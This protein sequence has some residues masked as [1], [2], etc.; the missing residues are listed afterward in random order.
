MGSAKTCFYFLPCGYYK[1]K[2]PDWRKTGQFKLEFKAVRKTAFTYQSNAMC[3]GQPN[4]TAPGSARESVEISRC[5]SCGSWI[6]LFLKAWFDWQ[7]D[8][9][10]S[11]SKDLRAAIRLFPF[12]FND[13]RG[14]GSLS[15]G[16]R[17]QPKVSSTL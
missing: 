6:P 10:G 12:L 3:W 15:P 8:E 7:F 11:Q 16:K 1:L 4:Y 14:T 9:G 2:Q 13:R 5:D 17:G